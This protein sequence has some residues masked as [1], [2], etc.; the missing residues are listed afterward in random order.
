M[1][2]LAGLAA[3][4][5][6]IFVAGC[7]VPD[8]KGDAP[9]RYR[10]AVFATV[11]ET[12]NVQ[13]GEAPGN[14]GTPQKLLLDVY[15]PAGDTAA[16]RPAM[17]WMH[18]G[19]FYS[20]TRKDNYIAELARRSAKRG[21][22]S[23]S[24]SYRLLAAFTC[25]GEGSVEFCAD[26][27]FAASDDERAAIRWLRKNADAL[28]IDT[29]RIAIGG[30][31]AGAVSSLL[32]GAAPNGSPGNS[33]NPGFSS[34]VKAVISISGALPFNGVFGEGDAPVLF[35]HGTKDNVVPYKWAVAN[36]DWMQDN[37][38]IAFPHF[39][40]GAGHTPVSGDTFE[41]MDRQ[42]RNFLYVMLSLGELNAGGTTPPRTSPLARATA[43]AV[44][45]GAQ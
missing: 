33:G 14:D 17:L 37:G 44:A 21:Y 35:W 18:G 25:G 3:L 45:E 9:L 1:T 16:K 19:G 43:A 4:V 2:F 5:A 8:P 10:D 38:P 36:V 41:D 22:V 11:K 32:V 31:S 6:A 13:Y 15:E 42:A 34:E 27:A 40:G 29:N 23:V 28:R 7:N 26:A 12:P 39:V 24:I 20:G 30:A